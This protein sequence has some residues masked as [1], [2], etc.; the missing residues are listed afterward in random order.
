MLL[1]HSILKEH[2]HTKRSAPPKINF[3]NSCRGRFFFVF[4]HS[5]FPCFVQSCFRSSDY[6]A[7]R[8]R[9]FGSLCRAYPHDPKEW[10]DDAVSEILDFTEPPVGLTPEQ[11]SYYFLQCARRLLFREHRFHQREPLR[12]PKMDAVDKSI[13]D[14]QLND[15]TWEFIEWGLRQ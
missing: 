3:E 14:D 11:V 10:I 8:A 2:V 15:E 7:Q 12:D 1:S 4:S 9:L 6:E 5:L 13:L